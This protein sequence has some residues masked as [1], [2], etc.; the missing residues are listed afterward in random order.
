MEDTAYVVTFRQTDPLYTLDLSDPRRPEVL[1]E[2]KIPGYSAYLHPVGEGMVL[3]VGQDATDDG[4]VRGTQ[5]SVFDV[6]DLSDPVRLDTY[7]LGEGTNSQA[8]YDHHAFLYWNGLAVVPV[9]QWWWDGSKDSGFM[10]AVGL[11]V[12]ADGE[13]TELGKVVHPGGDK[14]WDGRAQILRSVVVADSVYTISSK[15]MMK[16]SL[17]TLDTEAWLDF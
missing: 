5:V 2:L 11:S 16:S 8:E 7:T 15:G 6:S 1:G 3:G 9:Q 17:D 4:Q 13:L 10:G 14:N 12:A